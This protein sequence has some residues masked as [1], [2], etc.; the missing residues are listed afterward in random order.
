[1]RRRRGA[2]GKRWG[3]GGKTGRLDNA[4]KKQEQKR[5]RRGVIGK[6]RK[7]NLVGKKRKKR[8]V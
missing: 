2:K 6:G 1:M 4:T 5:R 3:R 8:E 7:R